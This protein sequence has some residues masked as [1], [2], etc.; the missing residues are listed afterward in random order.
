MSERKPLGRRWETW[1][2]EKI[3]E[4]KAEGGFERLEGHRKP[5]AG[6]DAPYDPLWWVKKLLVR[7]KL[8]ILPRALEVRASVDRAMAAVWALSS[9][10]HVRARVAAINAEIGRANRSAAE[11]PPTTLAPLDVEDVLAEWRR[12]RQPV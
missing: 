12:R 7:E 4:A 11:G 6:L 9:E 2:E 8:S 5:I 10:A 3:Q 1:I